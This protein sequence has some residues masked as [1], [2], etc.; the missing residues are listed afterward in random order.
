[1][2]DAP[3][4]CRVYCMH[5][6]LT[7]VPAPGPHYV[8]ELPGPGLSD[9]KLTAASLSQNNRPSVLA[10]LLLTP[11]YASVA[12]THSWVWKVATTHSWVC[13]VATTHSWVCKGWCYTLSCGK[14][15]QHSNFNF[16]I[17]GKYSLAVKYFIF[18]FLWLPF[19]NFALPIIA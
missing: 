10:P 11:G 9:I 8:N 14:I 15:S 6:P 13:K 19:A 12:A 16:Y 3:G 4:P 5:T 18:I 17:T 7:P 1:M 2:D